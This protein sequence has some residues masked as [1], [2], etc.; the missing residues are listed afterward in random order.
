MS[1]SLLSNPQYRRASARVVR[2]FI[3]DFDYPG[4]GSA[5]E[6][7]KLDE[8]LTYQLKLPQALAEMGDEWACYGNA[9]YR[10]HFP[11]DRYLI[12]RRHGA[13]YALEM[14]GDDAEFNLEELE[15][16][17][18]DPKNPVSGLVDVVNLPVIDI[19]ST[20]GTV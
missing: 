6:K 2:H 7:E 14:F 3:T 12:D 11:F 17:I 15:Y 5:E 1:F 8:Y 10:V 19:S 13:E 4:E 9:F 16:E 20:P 18:P